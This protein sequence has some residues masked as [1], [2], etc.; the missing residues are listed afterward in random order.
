MESK[1][2]D[3]LRRHD[4]LQVSRR[5]KSKKKMQSTSVVEGEGENID[6]IFDIVPD[7]SIV[8]IVT[9]LGY[10]DF[11]VVLNNNYVI[12]CHQKI[13]NKF[14]YFR[15]LQNFSEHNFR[16]CKIE[17][18]EITINDFRNI[19]KFLY[20]K[21][22]HLN[23]SNIKSIYSCSN[24]LGIQSLN[25]KCR[26]FLKKN[27]KFEE[28]LLW[29]RFADESMIL[30]LKWMLKALV[31]APNFEKITKNNSL[32][33]WSFDEF[34]TIVKSSRIVVTSEWKVLKNVL[35]WINFDSE[36]RLVHCKD[37]LKNVRFYY[38]TEKQVEL[39]FK[40]KEK[41]EAFRDVYSTYKVSENET[42]ILPKSRKYFK[43]VY[44][45]ERYGFRNDGTRLRRYSPYDEIIECL[46]PPRDYIFGSEFVIVKDKIYHIGERY[47]QVYDPVTNT[48]S[49]IANINIRRYEFGCVVY[50]D[51]IY[52]FG[53]T[54]SLD[55]QLFPVEK[56]DPTTNR[57][58]NLEV[59]LRRKNIK[60]VV[61]R[62][63]II[64]C[65]FSVLGEVL[66]VK[67]YMVGTRSIVYR[68]CSS[69]IPD[70]PNT[71][72]FKDKVWFCSQYTLNST[73]AVDCVVLDTRN[74][75]Y[76]FVPFR[77]PTKYK[78]S[79]K[80]TFIKM[81]IFINTVIAAIRFFDSDNSG[82]SLVKYSINYDSGQ[83]TYMPSETEQF[84]SGAD[85]GILNKFDVIANY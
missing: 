23:F 4:R 33:M 47:S 45:I 78:S 16:E 48:W 56:Y 63:K 30:E 64:F 21:E 42:K 27:I 66:F 19:F 59:S 28:V 65:G 58:S 62:N 26:K 46:A 71:F 70:T 37:L 52:V 39:C 53:G 13:I 1:I 18:S 15:A 11:E 43:G 82:T 22:I 77:I 36:N 25:K 81:T 73:C 9:K 57:W 76:L 80:I 5:M 84:S 35:E 85:V 7:E 51:E 41:G 38:I 40:D 14:E 83:L 34:K 61:V 54:N 24:Y 75:S 20:T 49:D 3:K 68:P 67:E 29:I 8:T 32:L 60:A 79:H 69:L 55:D 17:F 2:Y 10:C 72:A 44:L 50:N 31:N 6:S 74:Y 12:T